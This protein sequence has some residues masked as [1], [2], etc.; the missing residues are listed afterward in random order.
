MARRSGRPGMVK[1]W[2]GQTFSATSITTTQK[3]LLNFP[4]STD[5]PE[6]VLRT[7]GHLQVWGTPDAADD[8]AVIG[9][10]LIVVQES[11]ATVG[12]VSIPGPFDDLDADWLWHR[13]VMLR[14]NEVTADSD[15][16]LGLWQEIEV[17][18][19]AMRTVKRDQV[20]I[21][22]GETRSQTLAGVEV[23]GGIR[24]LSGLHR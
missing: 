17:D 18:S 11:A 14:V 23:Q 16:A 12:G 24:A 7:R 19:K 4:L 20:V 1:S 15:T 3:I 5:F 22:V 2:A 10:G 6:T 8:A 21:L 13:F 9:L